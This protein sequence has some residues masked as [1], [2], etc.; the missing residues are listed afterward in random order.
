MTTA[1]V[2]NVQRFSVHDGPGIRT[3]VFLKGCP[4]RC[5]WCHNPESLDA[6]PQVALKADRCLGC[7]LCAPACPEHLAGRLDLSPVTN[8]PDETCVR[9]GSCAAACPVEARDLLGGEMAVDE[10]MAEIERDRPYFEES[11]GGVT[12][13]GGEPVASHHALFLLACLRECGRTGIHRA[14]DTC[15][16]VPA[17]TLLEVAA[18]TDLLLYDLKLMDPARHRCAVGVD[19]G[20][21]LDNL[22][23]VVAA[24]HE[25]LVR[26]P[27]V[28]GRTDD[29]E[30]LEAL[31]DFVAGLDR[32]CPV[33]LLPYHGLGG[34]QYGRLGREYPLAGLDDPGSGH[35]A[36]AAEPL[37]A[38]G[39]DVTWGG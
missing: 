38:R 36:V 5:P 37:R 27:L 22:R 18:H 2:F 7:D 19:N 6:R 30:N 23:L 16:V 15:G 17:E 31:G 33:E 24:G 20:V 13:S 14:V 10:L 3:T 1:T 4:L 28:P 11:G 25:V 26:V 35:L 39:L 34:E 9:C 32:P 12:F 29:R 21:I 8:R